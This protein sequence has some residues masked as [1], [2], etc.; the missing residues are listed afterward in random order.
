MA[1]VGGGF[2]IFAFNLLIQTALG[3]TLTV[4]VLYNCQ[5]LS[6]KTRS[7][8]FNGCF[9]F[10]LLATVQTVFIY[11]SSLHFLNFISNA[12]Y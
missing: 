12:S 10:D 9:R 2:Q 7:K 5:S 8:K 6:K 11:N 3:D 4:H 1:I